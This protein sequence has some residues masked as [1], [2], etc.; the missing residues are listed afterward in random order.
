MGGG[1]CSGTNEEGRIVPDTYQRWLDVLAARLAAQAPPIPLAV[2][3]EGIGG[4]WI[5]AA[6]LNGPPTLDRL[7]R[8]VLE[9]AGLAHVIFLQGMNDIGNGASAEAIIAAEEKII[10]RVHAERVRIIAGTLFPLARPDRARWTASM[11]AQRIAVNS[12]IRTRAG[13]D[14][15]IDFDRLM[16]GGPRIDGSESLKTEFHCADLVHPN[17]AGYRAMG[18]FVDLELFKTRNSR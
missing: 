16:S 3:N 4:D 2:V 14:G 10:D 18:E 8:D 12:W 6:S 5:I 1:R 11:E 15:V 17:P 13:F 9:R 7:D